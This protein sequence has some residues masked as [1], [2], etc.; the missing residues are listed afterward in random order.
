MAT[1]PLSSAHPK[2]EHSLRSQLACLRFLL[3]PSVLRRIFAPLGTPPLPH[4]LTSSQICFLTVIRF[5]YGYHYEI[6][7]LLRLVPLNLTGTHCVIVIRFCFGCHS[8]LSL[9]PLNQSQSARSSFLLLDYVVTN[10]A[11]TCSL[12]DHI[13]EIDL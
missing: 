8:L 11:L 10:S 1:C 9:P 3:L 5:C 13:L 4:Q 7:T 2:E 6:W 12:V